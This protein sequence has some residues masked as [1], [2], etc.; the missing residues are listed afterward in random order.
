MPLIAELLNES[1]RAALEAAF[2]DLPWE[3]YRLQPSDPKPV[4]WPTREAFEKL[5][6]EPPR[7][8][9]GSAV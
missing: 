1:E 8:K 7:G 6:V 4:V 5:M 2:G 3:T 9:L